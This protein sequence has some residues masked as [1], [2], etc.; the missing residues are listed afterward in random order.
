V[1][2]SCNPSYSGSRDQEDHGSK[3]ALGQIVQETLSLKYPTQ[4][5]A[6][7]EVQVEK[8]LFRV[9]EALNSNPRTEKKKNA[10]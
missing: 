2:H 8:Y 3:P 7:K 4:N 6:G 5:R 10:C 9:H 1:A